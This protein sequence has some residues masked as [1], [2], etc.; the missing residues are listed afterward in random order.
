MLGSIEQFKPPGTKAATLSFID[1]VDSVR[2]IVVL[3]LVSTIGAQII[4][5]NL[6]EPHAGHFSICESVILWSIS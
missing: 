6:N 1:D 2:N 3:D 5:L 4:R